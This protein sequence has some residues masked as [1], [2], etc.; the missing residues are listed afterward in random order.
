MTTPAFC[1][2]RDSSAYGVHRSAFPKFNALYE[3][4]MKKAP[5]TQVGHDEP[6]EDRSGSGE[7]QR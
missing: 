5:W 4:L 2:V 6:H 3:Q 7:G 1:D